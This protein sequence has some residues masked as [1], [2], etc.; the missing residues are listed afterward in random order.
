VTKESILAIPVLAID[1]VMGRRDRVVRR[2]GEELTR[3]GYVVQQWKFKF[4]G[5]PVL[6]VPAIEFARR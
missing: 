6:T 4:H 2:L 1:L 5:Q 3:I